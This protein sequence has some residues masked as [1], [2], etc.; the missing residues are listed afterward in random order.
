M[1]APDVLDALG[2]PIAEVGAV[3]VAVESARL[4][5]PAGD[6]RVV[7]LLQAAWSG[8]LSAE[9]ELSG[10]GQSLKRSVKLS[11]AEVR[12]VRLPLTLADGASP[13]QL[14]VSAKI[15]EGAERIRAAWL[16]DEPASKP[17]EGVGAALFGALKQA[18]GKSEKRPVRRA[19]E[20]GSVPVV[21]EAVGAALPVAAEEETAWSPGMPVPEAASL[22][23]V[24]VAPPPS[25]H[26][27]VDSAGERPECPACYA[28]ADLEL[29][30]AQ[31]HCPSCGHTWLL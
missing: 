9:L 5:W 27:R 14:R 13:L 10:G 16:K 18:L 31:R 20:Q 17:D 11:P 29:I 23:A 7:L 1:Q 15:P 4:Y 24:D 3:Q 2:L 8:D 21:L 30:K 12:R 22:R 19:A 6:A 26:S 28:R 25:Q